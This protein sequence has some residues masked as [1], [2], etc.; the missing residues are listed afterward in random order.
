[1]NIL[2]W[3]HQWDPYPFI[4][5]NLF[6]SMQ[7]AYAAP[8]IMMSQNRQAARDR[9][10]AHNDFLLNQKAE[11]E[12]RLLLEHQEAQNAVL[13][14]LSARLDAVAQAVHAPDPKPGDTKPGDRHQ[15]Y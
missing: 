12:V 3:V 8:V 1:M 5:L 7:A 14:Q 10:E 6:L 11:V 9:L 15:V 2:A 13:A 4:L